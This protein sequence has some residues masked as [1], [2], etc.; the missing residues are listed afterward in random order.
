MLRSLVSSEMFIRDRPISRSLGVWPG[1]DLV[2]GMAPEIKLKEG[3]GRAAPE[4]AR[5]DRRRYDN[6]SQIVE[7]MAELVLQYSDQIEAERARRAEDN[8]G[9]LYTSDVTTDNT[10]V[11][12]DGQLTT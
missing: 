12:L 10:T 5:F 1:R 4:A 3:K 9:H 2:R 11:D 7:K 8:T 6:P